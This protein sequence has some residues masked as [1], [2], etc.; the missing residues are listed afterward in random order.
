[1]NQVIDRGFFKLEE[2]S[3]S[4]S[5]RTS[6]EKIWTLTLNVSGEKVNKLSTKVMSQFK[7][8]L[9]ELE[10]LGSESKID[11]LILLSGK[12]GQFIAG[13]DLELIQSVSSPEQAEELS[14][15][16]QKLMDCWEDLSFPTV[17]AIEGP[18]LGGGCEFSLASTA[19]LMSNDP[20]ARMGL[21]EVLLG[22]IPG[23][24]GTIRL[25]RKIG[26]TGALDLILTGRT[27]NANQA[28]QIGLIEG[29]LPQQGFKDSVIQWTRKNLQ[30]MKAGNRLAKVP[31][32]PLLGEVGGSFR[33]FFE[34]SPIQ[35]L[36][37]N[38]VQKRILA[39][40]KGHYPA[41][42]EILNVIRSTQVGYG[43]KLRGKARSL[44]LEREA[45]G[46]G[47]VATTE[48]S[49]NLIRLFFLTEKMKKS[50]GLQSGLLVPE[51]RI[52]KAV[53]LGAGVMGGGIAQLFAEKEISTRM[54]D[55]HLQALSA[56][57]QSA[58]KIFKKK[59]KKKK[60][61]TEA[62]FTKI[63]FNCPCYGLFWIFISRRRGR[64]GCRKHGSQK[65]AFC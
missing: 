6:R 21:P 39:K 37:L 5:S 24:G 15:E 17:A 42:F 25:P 1:M 65:E 49:K 11:A 52:E 38:Q 50:N 9:P 48:I 58:A 59:C 7:A 60:T 35:S 26:L 43:E 4:E 2:Q 53:V 57:I 18:A 61:D 41:P 34:K 54:K 30:S 20:V 47:K 19:I 8:L 55:V 27:L 44:A 14:R 36:I 45:Q 31:K 32:M 40:T 3:S 12:P 62:V 29:S 33:S 64:S 23:M 51:H 10:A 56:G 46:F 16:G 13:A 22:L 63:K 28:Y